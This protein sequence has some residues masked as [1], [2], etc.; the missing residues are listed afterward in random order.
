MN[1]TNNNNKDLASVII[2]NG[3]WYLQMSLAGGV[4]AKYKSH[5]SHNQIHTIEFA[6]IS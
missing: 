2:L 1:K 6:K 5:L 3:F 4:V